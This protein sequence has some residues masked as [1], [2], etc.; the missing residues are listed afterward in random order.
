MRM[1]SHTICQLPVGNVFDGKEAKR[2][3]MS[4][5]QMQECGWRT[6]TH[7]FLHREGRNEGTNQFASGEMGNGNDGKTQWKLLSR[8]F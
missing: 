2:R 1:Y 7:V 4:P 3:K 8:G 5:F 6:R